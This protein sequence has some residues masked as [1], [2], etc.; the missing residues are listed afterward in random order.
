MERGHCAST[1]LL[2]RAM[3]SMAR[4]S[5]SSPLSMSPLSSTSVAEKSSSEPPAAMDS[6][7]V[8]FPSLLASTYQ[9]GS[10]QVRYEDT[11]REERGSATTALSSFFSPLT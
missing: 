1:G 11:R 2:T 8:I 10:P 6:P 7:R 4:K 9:G 5:W 3:M